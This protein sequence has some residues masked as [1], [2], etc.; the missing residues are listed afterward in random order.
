MDLN[1]NLQDIDALEG[2]GLDTGN[3]HAPSSTDG[4]LPVLWKC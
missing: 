4:Y 2:D 3:G 1:I